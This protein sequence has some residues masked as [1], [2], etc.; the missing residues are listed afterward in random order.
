MSDQIN[1]PQPQEETASEPLP[2]EEKKPPKLTLPK[3]ERSCP[4]CHDI[5]RDPVILPCGHSL[6]SAGTLEREGKNVLL[7]GEEIQ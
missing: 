3:E 7:V 2:L 4:V 1:K 6:L 5:F